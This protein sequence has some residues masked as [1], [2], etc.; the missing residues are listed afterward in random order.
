M[1]LTIDFDTPK[2]G[3][4]RSVGVTGTVARNS[5]AYLTIRLNVT[6]AISAGRNRSF[7][8]VITYDNTASG[9]SLAVNASYTLSIVP[10]FIAGDTVD[11]STGVIT[12]W[13]YTI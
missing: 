8:R 3:T 11:E 12:A 9:T 6:N 7:Y 10:K 2:T 13:S 4:P 5:L 1:A